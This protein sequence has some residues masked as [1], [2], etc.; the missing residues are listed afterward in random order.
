MT[1][2]E[3]YI[4]KVLGIDWEAY[5]AHQENLYFKL[6]AK[7]NAYQAEKVEYMP[8]YREWFLYEW[9]RIDL[10]FVKWVVS[11]ADVVRRN[12]ITDAVA[13]EQLNRT[14]QMRHL[15]DI[16]ESEDRISI[17]QQLI[18]NNKHGNNQN[19]CIKLMRS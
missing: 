13:T 1:K 6:A 2:L 7:I 11:Y 17:I 12:G 15:A 8:E 14:Y 5:T 19:S 3:A 16:F 10:E 18:N 9:R 4:L